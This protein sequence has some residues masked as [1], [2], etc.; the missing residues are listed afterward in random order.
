V[1]R[2]E[3][4]FY[5]RRENV[6]IHRRL[7]P[8]RVQA[9]KAIREKSSYLFFCGNR[10]LEQLTLALVKESLAAFRRNGKA[11]LQNVNPKDNMILQEILT[12]LAYL[13]EVGVESECPLNR[14]SDATHLLVEKFLRV[15]QVAL[16]STHDI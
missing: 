15:I 8:L 10:T 12:D 13:P 4:I 11:G 7:V 3:V 14:N 2:V 6:E 9:C 5:R 16:E 1:H